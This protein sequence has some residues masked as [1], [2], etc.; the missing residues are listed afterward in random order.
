MPFVPACISA[1]RF[2][3][4]AGPEWG[5]SVVAP[6]PEGLVMTGLTLGEQDYAF[7]EADLPGVGRT[8]AFTLSIQIWR[9]R[10]PEPE[11][12]MLLLPALA[13]L[14]VTCRGRRRRI[15]TPAE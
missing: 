4:A 10:V 8:G 2:F 9:T 11:T 1:C 14:A 12:W 13:G 3:F 7:W 6:A 5:P 15:A